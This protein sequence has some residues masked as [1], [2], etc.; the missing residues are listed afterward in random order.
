M[1]PSFC[2]PGAADRLLLWTQE[3]CENLKRF[4]SH[5][6]STPSFGGERLLLR[7]IQHNRMH[8]IQSQ[9]TAAG[10]PLHT[11][12]PQLLWIYEGSWRHGCCHETYSCELA[13]SFSFRTVNTNVYHLCKS[14]FETRR[15]IILRKHWVTDMQSKDSHN[16]TLIIPLNIC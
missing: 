13:I 5:P 4:C 10:F 12:V 11:E 9:P 16:L 1:T 3:P 6:V 15:W 14:W 8:E 7:K 2:C